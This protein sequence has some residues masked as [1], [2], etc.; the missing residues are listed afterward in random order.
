MLD[1]RLI[2]DNPDLIKQRLANRCGDYASMVDEVLAIDS[3]RRTAE[4]ER[5]KLQS[6]RNRISKEIGIA[7]KNGQDT[8]A[9]E[10][11]VRGIGTRIDEIGLEADA[12]DV[13]QRDLLLGIAN[14]P[15]D[16]CPVGHSAEENPEVRCR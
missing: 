8:S 4:T 3:A 16:A 2:R 15:H 9:I 5:Q 11:E 1:I 7:K 12:A 10:T 13:R 14:L 6:D